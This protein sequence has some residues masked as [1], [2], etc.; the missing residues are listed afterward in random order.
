MAKG[1]PMSEEAKRKSS[2]SHMGN[3]GYWTGKKRSLESRLNISKGHLGQ[4]PWNKGIKSSPET[5]K[6]L[7]ESHLG[8]KA[9]NKGLKNHL[10][11]DVVEQIRMSVIANPNRTFRDTVP[12]KKVEREL[13][14]LKVRYEKQRALCKIAKVDFY[15]PEEHVVIQVDGCYWHNCPIH[16][17]IILEG[18]TE[19]DRNQDAVL[20]SNGFNVYRIWEHDIMATN[21]DLS[22]FVKL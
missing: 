16:S 4:T 18:K 22:N 7:R 17:E 9:W 10:S 11:K 6:K 14:R 8:Q 3:P 15:L 1:V 20:T 21:F 5:I 13:I 19:R 12:E 2:L